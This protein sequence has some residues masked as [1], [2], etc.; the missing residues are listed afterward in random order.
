M[1]PLKQFKKNIE[2]ADYYLSMYKELRSLKSLG[3]RGRLDPGNQYLLWLPRAAIV[4]SLS[5]LDAYVHQVLY[6][7]IP[8]VLGAAD[9]PISEK[10]AE[11]VTRVM[12]TRKPDETR[13]AIVYVRSRHGAAELADLMVDSVL[14]YESYQQPDNLV[15]AY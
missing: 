11:L 6:A 4:S 13:A 9:G 2:A 8:K 10:L 12:P 3:S 15:Q 1:T 14:R 5:S 7:R